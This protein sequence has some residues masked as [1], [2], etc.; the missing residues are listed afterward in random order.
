MNLFIAINFKE[1]FKSPVYN[2]QTGLLNGG[3]AWES[4]PA[5]D[6]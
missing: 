2:S 6:Y 3:N 1:K 5:P 4:N